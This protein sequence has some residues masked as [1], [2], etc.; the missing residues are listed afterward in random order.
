MDVLLTLPCFVFLLLLRSLLNN[1][2]AIAPTDIYYCVT[3]LRHHLS[4]REESAITVQYL[5][6]GQQQTVP[7]R[8]GVRQPAGCM[9]FSWSVSLWAG[10]ETRLN[11][12]W[13]SA[14]FMSVCFHLLQCLLSLFK[15][16]HTFIFLNV[17]LQILFKCFQPYYSFKKKIVYALGEALWRNLA[18]KSCNQMNFGPWSMQLYDMSGKLLKAEFLDMLCKSLKKFQ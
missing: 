11:S 6:R 15:S 3:D 14:L 13:L 17:T 10:S 1:L 5:L 7:A 2:V 8:G 12:L 4:T 9:Q 16:F 18:Y